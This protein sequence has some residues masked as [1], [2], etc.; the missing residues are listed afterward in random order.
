MASITTNDTRCAS[1]WSAS[2]RIAD[3]SDD[4]VV[5]MVDARDPRWILTHTLASRFDTSIPQQRGWMTSMTLP[6]SDRS[7]HG[8]ASGEGEEEM[9]DSDVRARGNNPRFQTRDDTLIHQAE[10]RALPLQGQTGRSRAGNPTMHPPAPESNPF[11]T[12]GG[13][14]P[15]QLSCPGSGHNPAVFPLGREPFCE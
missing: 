10:L 2:S 11:P 5:T 12:H 1:R 15:G 14:S 7:G 8:A 4:Q 13:R 6:P 3:D 9:F